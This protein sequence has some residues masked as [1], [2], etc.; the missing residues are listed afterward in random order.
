MEKFKGKY[1]TLFVGSMFKISF[2][3]VTNTKSLG[4]VQRSLNLTQFTI[5]VTQT[6]VWESEAGWERKKDLAKKFDCQV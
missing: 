4:C 3:L 6:F 2:M 1:I 5:S